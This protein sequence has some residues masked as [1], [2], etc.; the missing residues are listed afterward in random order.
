MCRK[1]VRFSGRVVFRVL[2]GAA[3]IANYVAGGFILFEWCFCI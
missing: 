1:F 2:E 3:A